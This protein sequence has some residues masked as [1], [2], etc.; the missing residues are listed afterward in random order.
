M[1]G[2][3]SYSWMQFFT[4]NMKWSFG[5]RK[6]KDVINNET[7]GPGLLTDVFCMVTREENP[8]AFLLTPLL[9][10]KAANYPLLLPNPTVCFLHLQI[11]VTLIDTLRNSLKPHFHLKSHASS[12]KRRR[13]TG[14]YGMAEPQ[15]SH[16]IKGTLHNFLSAIYFPSLKRYDIK[17]KK[18]HFM[19]QALLID[20]ILICFGISNNLI[21]S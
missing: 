16:K 15:A 14:H 3:L 5:L 1:G 10:E 21:M 6:N 18:L 12:P 8:T 7:D 13:L 17:E 2:F 20:C 11:S 9:W 19:W 4:E